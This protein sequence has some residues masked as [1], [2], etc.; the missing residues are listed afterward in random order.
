MKINYV[1]KGI[2]FGGLVG[3]LFASNLLN[4]Q[5]TYT[6][7]PAAATGSA[8]PTQAM[9]N[10][11]YAATNLSGSVTVNTQGIQE[12]T[13]PISGN[14]RII[15]TGGQGWGTYGGRG[16]SIAGDF[17][18]TAGTVLKIVVGQLAGAPLN[19]L[20]QYG[21]GGGSFVTYTNNV[22]LIVAGG[23]GGSWATSFQANSDGTVVTSGNPGLNGAAANGAGGTAGG[24]GATASSADG[25]GGLTGNGGGS[26]PGLAFVNG[27]WGGANRGQ[28][29][30]GGG[31]GTSSWDNQRGGGGGGYSGGGASA[32]SS[33]SG[34]NPQGG[35]GGSYNNGAN[36]TN[37]SGVNL[38]DGRVIIQE[39]CSIKIT[40]SGTNSLNPVLCAGNSLTLTTNAI[41]NYSWSNGN[42]T[43]SVIVVSPTTSTIVTVSGTSSLNCT[44]VASIS[45]TVSSA[46]PVL[47]VTTG[48]NPIC[49]GA[50]TSLSATGAVSYT[51]SGGISNGQIISP[52]VTTNYTVS[53]QNGCGITTAVRTITVAPLSISVSANPT[54][55]CEGYTTAL[56]AVSPVNGFTWSPS[57]TPITGSNVIVAPLSTTIYTVSAS[58]GTCA[59]TQTVLVTTKTTP[60]IV[61]STTFVTVC[62]GQSVTLSASGAGV[63]GSY[64]WSPGGGTTQSITIAPTTSTLYTVIGT[65]S[66]NCSNNTSI[67]IQVATGPTLVLATNKSLICNGGSATLT[68]NGAS[69]YS[70]TNGPSTAIYNVSPSTSTTYTCVAAGTTNTCLTTSTVQVNV[71]TPNVA[72]TPSTQ[73]CSGNSAVISAS[74]ANTY[75]WTG[76]GPGASYT[77]T[78]ATTTTYTLIANSVSLTVNCQSTLT[79]LVKVNANPSITI[80]PTKSTTICKGVTNVLTAGGAQTYLWNTTE[81]T[82]SISVTPSVTTTYSVTGYDANNCT[83]T[84]FYIVNVSKCQG[85]AEAS[86]ENLVSVYPNPNNGD[87]TIRSASKLH[88]VL[89]NA[90]GQSIRSL[91]LGGLSSSEVSISDLSAGVYFIK[92]ANDAS[93]K[94]L[95]IIV[96]K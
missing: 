38:G 6:F 56:T 2:A 46:A 37:V 81:T 73:V 57:I 91:D 88:L 7:T 40:A 59:G 90:L 29:G 75:T 4:A 89:Y 30:F 67:P 34:G 21:G 85:I 42:T 15:A 96:S 84:Q 47:T 24:G 68:A 8:G 64:V 80:V 9:V 65:N 1:K 17:S 11:A 94:G 86:L 51:W 87:F 31:G 74:N 50:S 45:I 26:A 18:L 54:L 5:Q 22:P 83:G 36:Q 61:P 93:D 10:S 53:G 66:L 63:N 55:V 33:S 32:H 41:S 76:I 12:F 27:A 39:L 20:N 43:S 95:K 13:I 71:F 23:G 44:T 58:D 82:A 52:T 3:L 28:G 16:A 70:W 69:T 14:Y 60:S 72:I 49:A 77:V 48:Q 35:G 62:L 92:N 78:P 25:G 19:S 79:T